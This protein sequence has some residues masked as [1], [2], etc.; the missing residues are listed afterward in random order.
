M[1]AAQKSDGKRQHLF[2]QRQH[3]NTEAIYCYVCIANYTYPLLKFSSLFHI[4]AYS[5]TSL[6]GDIGTC[7][8]HQIHVWY[9]MYEGLLDQDI[10]NFQKQVNTFNSVRCIQQNQTESNAFKN[11]SE[12]TK[13]L[14]SFWA[15]R[16]QPAIPLT[17]TIHQGILTFIMF[18]LFLFQ[19][20]DD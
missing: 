13:T 19:R 6:W 1:V 2:Y 17:M 14:W 3:L 20:V 10:V 4:I 12:G 7:K 16:L 9:K 15:A 8:K 5:Y 11:V 18:F